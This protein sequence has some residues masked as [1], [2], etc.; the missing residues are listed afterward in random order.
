ML[1]TKLTGVYNI[2]MKPLFIT[3]GVWTFL[4]FEFAAFSQGFPTGYCINLILLMGWAF[5]SLA[6]ILLIAE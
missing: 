1:S 2:S 6:Y 3:L 4:V 5:G